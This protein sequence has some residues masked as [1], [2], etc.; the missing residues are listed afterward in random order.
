MKRIHMRSI[1][2]LYIRYLYIWFNSLKYLKYNIILLA[3][4]VI[5]D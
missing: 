3:I 5:L 4:V 1:A 2:I